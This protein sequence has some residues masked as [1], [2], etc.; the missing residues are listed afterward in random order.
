MCIFGWERT[1]KAVT[2]LERINILMD[3]ILMEASVLI[4]N[5]YICCMLVCIIYMVYAYIF[6]Q[7]KFK[8]VNSVVSWITHTEIFLACKGKTKLT[9]K[10]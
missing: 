10:L 8:F 5:M 3:V 7:I 6:S 2:A 4:L 1:S 9:N